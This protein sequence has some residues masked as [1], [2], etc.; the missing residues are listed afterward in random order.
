M[1]RGRRHGQKR[2]SDMAAS[3][4]A[5]EQ[6]EQERA[7]SRSEHAASCTGSR[8]EHAASCR[9]VVARFEARQSRKV[10]LHARVWM[11]WE[12]HCRCRFY[13]GMWFSRRVLSETSRSFHFFFFY[14][15]SSLN[16][17]RRR[18]NPIAPTTI[19]QLRERQSTKLL[20]VEIGRKEEKAMVC[21]HAVHMISCVAGK[22]ALCRF[23]HDGFGVKD[24]SQ[25]TCRLIFSF[26]R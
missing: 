15:H 7:G 26:H 8:S 6:Q 25:T 11:C 5:T 17:D 1:R 23:R 19:T 18:T 12:L 22:E 13:F 2:R 21:G 20:E 16:Q 10:A 24:V 14:T 4:T 9:S 3:T